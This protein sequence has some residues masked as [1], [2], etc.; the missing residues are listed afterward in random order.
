MNDDGSIA[1]KT[2]YRQK[3]WP[4]VSARDW[5]DYRWQLANRLHG[6]ADLSRLLGLGGSEFQPFERCISK[7]RWAVTPYYLSL[8][9]E[10][11][12]LSDPIGRQF[13]PDPREITVKSQLSSAD[14]LHEHNYSPVKGLI[15]RYR[16]RALIL[17]WPSCSCYCR[18]CNRKRTWKQPESV[19]AKKEAWRAIFHYIKE[20]TEIR[21]I[22]LSGGDP[23]LMPLDRLESILKKLKDIKNVKVLRIGTRLPV[24]LPMAITH[25]LCRMLSRYRPLWLN[26]HFNHPR[27][28]TH[29]ARQA[30]TRLQ[31]AGIPVSNQSVLLK[32][33]N[34]DI[35]IMK[36]LCCRLQEIMVR[37][38]YLFHCDFVQGTDHF[39]TKIQK[40]ID[41]I[42][43]MWGHTGGMCIPNY[44]VDLPAGLGKARVMPPH[45][46]KLSESMALFKTFEGKTVKLLFR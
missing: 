12:L 30:C 44:V 22:L 39:R 1:L 25:K 3:L 4:D 11:N 21:E 35:S 19:P 34:D 9:E 36:D 18:H 20:H 40:G 38:Y 37:P 8:I 6:A 28:I 15:H 43:K 16:D 31:E 41:I 42:D 7:Y 26:T 24:V 13:I 32:G 23:L 45:M 10:E 29:Q 27:E 46:A 5:A 17:A 2:G 14:P 33:I